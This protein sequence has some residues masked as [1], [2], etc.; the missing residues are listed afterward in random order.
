MQTCPQHH[1][2][3]GKI[4]RECGHV[5]PLATGDTFGALEVIERIP[6]PARLHLY[7][8]RHQDQDYA[9]WEGLEIYQP[10]YR[11]QMIRVLD[12]Q[13]LSGVPEVQNFS[14]DDMPSEAN[15]LYLL[16]DW[17][18]YASSQTLDSLS[19]QAGILPAEQI[20]LIMT[21]LLELLAELE[22]RQWV[23]NSFHSHYL[24]FDPEQQKV[25]PGLAFYAQELTPGAISPVV[26]KGFSPPEQIRSGEV[27]RE[28]DRFGLAMTLV[29]LCTGLS[30]ALWAPD[31][32]GFKRYQYIWGKALMDFYTQLMQPVEQVPASRLIDSWKALKTDLLSHKILPAMQEELRVFNAGLQAY[33]AQD[34]NTALEN[35]L[36][37]Q[38]GSLHNPHLAAYIARA[39]WKKHLKHEALAWYGEAIRRE[40]LGLF[41]Q[42]VG[43]CYEADKQ[44]ERAERAYRQAVTRIPYMPEPYNGLGRCAKNR[45]NFKTAKLCFEKSLQIHPTWEAREMLD[46]IAAIQFPTTHKSKH[47][48]Q[49]PTRASLQ[50]NLTPTLWEHFDKN[51]NIA[52]YRVKE[53]GEQIGP[54]TIDAVLRERNL[55]KGNRSSIYRVHN[56]AA[57][58]FF[59]KEVLLDVSGSGTFYKE[60]VLLQKLS[61][62]GI[63]PVHD[64]FEAN[65]CGYLVQPFLQVPSLEQYLNTEGILPEA[66]IR[67]ILTQGLQLIAYLQSQ[68]IIHADIKPENLHWDAAAQQLYL[69]DFD[70]AVEHK[71]ARP[72]NN[73]SVGVTA[74]FAAPEQLEIKAVNL[75]TDVFA[76]A[77]T[78]LNLSTGLNPKLFYHHQKRA[79]RSCTQLPQLSRPFGKFLDKLLTC[80]LKQRAQ[81]YQQ[82]QD[83]LAELQQAFAQAPK[84]LSKAQ[85][86]VGHLI[87]EVAL[88]HQDPERLA[89]IAAQL[90]HKS[91]DAKVD[92]LL[93][94]AYLDHQQWDAAF[95]AYD[96]AMA[97]DPRWLLPYYGKSAALA[98]QGKHSDAIALLKKSLDYCKTES[99][100]YSLLAR[101]FI[102]Q[103][104]FKLALQLYQKALKLDPTNKQ[105]YLDTAHLHIRLGGFESARKLCEQALEYAPTSARAFQLLQMICGIQE[106]YPAAIEYG[107]RAA[108]LRPHRI[109]VQY[110]LGFSYFRAGYYIKALKQFQRCLELD[111][112]HVQSLYYLADSLLELGRLEE[113][114]KYFQKVR[115]HAELQEAVKRK[116]ALIEDSLSQNTAA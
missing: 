30:P 4:C 106:N 56:A 37:V 5:Y 78:C 100:P 58:S 97:K 11:E 57:E 115:L 93:A 79:Y 12:A 53:V 19:Q 116:L 25:F 18:P 87:R 24:Y 101:C 28:T 35:W 20:H 7:H 55:V 77:L 99:L 67:A 8:C 92:Y 36:S 86:E 103:K 83:L 71:P 50:I 68:Q 1:L 17:A 34:L 105:I 94:F 98:D 14:I 73:F 9:L 111:P 69:T 54:Y 21:Q 112:E 16:Y 90:H 88:C 76:L 65:D 62:P 80:D 51:K 75:T 39:L 2:K 38:R 45:Q 110:D 104:K 47:Q 102:A 41:Y 74:G 59:V 61:H 108:M 48:P 63:P 89:A 84:V 81:R 33:T 49:T 52:A 32:P 10:T 72:Q 114:R 44:T 107:E 46:E 40:S 42:E 91:Q 29:Q 109:N 27:F 95:V 96:R 43:A 3:T 13:P 66:E 60:K 64:S 6:G 113:A 70:I 31:L 22:L 23:W 85:R 26:F 15:I 82:A